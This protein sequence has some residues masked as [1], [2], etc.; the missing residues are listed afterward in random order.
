MTLPLPLLRKLQE[1]T[2]A[3]AWA[4]IA[5]HAL[6]VCDTAGQGKPIIGRVRIDDR[7]L[8]LAP[9]SSLLV[10][11]EVVRQLFNDGD[12]DCVWLVVGAPA[13]AANTLEMTPEQLAELYPDGPRA[14][15]P[16][17]DGDT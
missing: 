13:E 2:P 10:D 5:E 16:E 15:P 1:A 4:A 8:T 17:L 7:S 12:A 9:G 14:L 3:E 6:H 11:P